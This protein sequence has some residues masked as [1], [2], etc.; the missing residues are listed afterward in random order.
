MAIT[1]GCS[2]W[3]ECEFFD[4]EVPVGNQGGCHREFRARAGLS[5][6]PPLGSDSVQYRSTSE[7][8]SAPARGGPA[9]LGLWCPAHHLI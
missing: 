5:S 3:Y 2:A 4:S 6:K 7:R 1:H 8:A 9:S